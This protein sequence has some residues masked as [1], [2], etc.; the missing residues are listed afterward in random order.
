MQVWKNIGLTA[1]LVLAAAVLIFFGVTRFLPLLSQQT[2][3]D[4]TIGVAFSM[5][6]S[7][8]E[9]PY[10]TTLVKLFERSAPQGFL[11]V[12]Y[13]RG[14][15]GY[16]ARLGR[17]LLEHV[18]AETAMFFPARYGESYVSVN[19]VKTIIIGKDAVEHVFTYTDQDGHPN[20]VRMIAIIWDFDSAYYFVEQ[21]LPENF[22]RLS[23]DLD[24]LLKT[25]VLSG[26]TDQ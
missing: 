11:T 4:E 2:Y 6:E 10:S 26:P 1:V 9:S 17:S 5:H 21:G 3:R 7:Y 12:K 18:Y 16:A 23:K 19:L 15:G 8:K 20:Q 13:E 14:L 24:R 22:T 25:L